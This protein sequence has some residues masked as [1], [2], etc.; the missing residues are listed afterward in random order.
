M[1]PKKIQIFT[2]VC[3]FFLFWERNAQV[4]IASCNYLQT[5]IKKKTI[6]KTFSG[7]KNTYFENKVNILIHTCR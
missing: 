6:L 7:G 3:G 5:K 4:V 2:H 1:Y